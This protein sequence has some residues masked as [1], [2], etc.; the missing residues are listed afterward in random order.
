M[1]KVGLTEVDILK[2]IVKEQ[3]SKSTEASDKEEFVKK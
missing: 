1:S 3:G 2:N